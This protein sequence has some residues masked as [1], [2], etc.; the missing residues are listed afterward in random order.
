MYTTLEF[1]SSPLS[2]RNRSVS[3]TFAHGPVLGLRYRSYVRVAPDVTIQSYLLSL[4]LSS[5]PQS[6]VLER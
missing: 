3:V 5:L 2:P 1:Y 6:S 4:V